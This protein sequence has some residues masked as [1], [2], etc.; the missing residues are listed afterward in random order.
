MT[1]YLGA[2]SCCC[3]VSSQ[4]LV[5]ASV[6]PF[7]SLHYSDL[8]THLSPSQTQSLSCISGGGGGRGHGQGRESLFS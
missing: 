5:E 8:Y 1:V 4:H 6:E 7:I 2:V 3:L